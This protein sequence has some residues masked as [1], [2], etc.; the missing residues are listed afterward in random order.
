MTPVLIPCSRNARPRKGLVRRPQWNQHGCHSLKGE[1]NE[2]GRS[3]RL[4]A[5]R[6][7]RA[8]EDQPGRPVK[9]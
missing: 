1:T 4:N 2:F 8:L 9:R 3:I 7:M 5:A 6:S